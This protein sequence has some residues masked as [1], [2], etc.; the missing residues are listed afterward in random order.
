MVA[1]DAD[2]V[3][4]SHD[5]ADFD[6]LRDPQEEALSRGPGIPPP[7]PF[8]FFVAVNGTQT[9]PYFITELAAKAANG[10]LTRDTLIW[11]EG[12]AEWAAAGTVPELQSLLAAI[13]P[14]LP[15]MYKKM[16]S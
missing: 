3:V 1:F 14:P 6:S 15:T 13:P 7:I 12:M 4:A 16:T 11:R 9:G 5:T 2:N 8:R 10:S